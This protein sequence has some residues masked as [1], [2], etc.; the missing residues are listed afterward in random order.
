MH[1]LSI[2]FYS[3]PTAFG[4]PN[5]SSFCMKAVTYLRGIAYCCGCGRRRAGRMHAFPIARD[6][7]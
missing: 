7:Q 3:F 6:C 2:T 5:A 4:L 1:E